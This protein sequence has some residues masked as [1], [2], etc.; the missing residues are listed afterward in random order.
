MAQRK[1]EY[2]RKPR[3][4]YE[5]PEWVTK[6]LVDALNEDKFTKVNQHRIWE[7]ACAGGKIANY[8]D[9]H[10]ASDLVT[11]F[12]T[13]GVDFLEQEDVPNNCNAII[14]NPPFGRNAE[15]FIRHSLKLLEKGQLQFVAMLLPVDFDSGKTRYDMFAGSAFFYRKLVLTSRIVWFANPDKK[16]ENPSTNHAWFVWSRQ[17]NGAV[18]PYDWLFKD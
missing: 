11:D 17:Q 15:R 5:T 7:P 3:D 4:L 13:P 1:S 6:L 10:Y 9:A 12:G 16:K 8:V 2:E 14:T 18:R